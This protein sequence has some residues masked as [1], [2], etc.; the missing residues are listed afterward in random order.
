MIIA[1]AFLGFALASCKKT[2]NNYA[3][4]Q[5]ASSVAVITGENYSHTEAYIISNQWKIVGRDDS[6]NG[7]VRVWKLQVVGTNNFL[8][9]NPAPATKYWAEGYQK[10]D[11]L[12][13]NFVSTLSIKK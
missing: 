13:G 4:E 7:N 9:I 8:N 6:D 3:P 12:N 5:S 2:Y 11:V 10:G 1:I